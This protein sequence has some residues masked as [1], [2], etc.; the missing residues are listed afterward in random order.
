MWKKKKRRPRTLYDVHP[1]ELKRAVEKMC[2]ELKISPLLPGRY[3]LYKACVQ[4]RENEID[5]RLIL[6]AA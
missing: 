1:R 6:L 2:R 4:E 3:D 5:E